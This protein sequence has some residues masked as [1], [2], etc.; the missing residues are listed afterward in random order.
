MSKND[1][2]WI[3][4]V[5]GLHRHAAIVICLTCSSFDLEGNNIDHESLKKKDFKIAEVLHYKK[6]Q[7]SPI[8]ALNS[9]MKGDFDAPMLM[10]PLP[11]QVLLPSIEKKTISMN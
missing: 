10:K 6:P 5:E 7:L 2:L 3:S 8:Q 4:F 11:I 1:N 9:I